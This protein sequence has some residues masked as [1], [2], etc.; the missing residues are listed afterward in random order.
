MD[1]EKFN[2]TQGSKF[3]EYQIE[4]RGGSITME[5]Y[6]P[7]PYLLLGAPPRIKL[8]RLRMEPFVSGRNMSM[9]RPCHSKGEKAMHALLFGRGRGCSPPSV[10]MHSL[11]THTPRISIRGDVSKPCT[12]IHTFSEHQGKV[13]SFALKCCQWREKLEG[14]RTDQNTRKKKR[15]RNE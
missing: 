3:E 6:L 13:L 8:G 9:V 11:R 7:Q 5:Q 2:N 1:L 4:I 12:R 14:A 10:K 15:T